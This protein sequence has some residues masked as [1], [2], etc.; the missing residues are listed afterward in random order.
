MSQ[1]MVQCRSERNKF[2]T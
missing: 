2:N 1:E